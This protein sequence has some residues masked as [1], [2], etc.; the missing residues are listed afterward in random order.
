MSALGFRKH[1]PALD[2][3]RGLAILL[4]FFYHYAGGLTH[5][6]NSE[7]MRI[8]GAIFGFGWSGVDLFFVLS[9]FLITGILFDTQDDPHYFKN[10]YVRRSLRIFPV[11]YLFLLIYGLLAHYKFGVHLSL[12]HISFLFYVGYP[13]ALLWPSLA[14]ISP[15]VAIT[16][17]W[18]LAAEEQFYMVWPWL[19]WALKKPRTIIAACFAITVFS[20]SLRILF[21]FTGLHSAAWDY[22]FLPARMD[23]LAIGAIIAV[24]M[25]GRTREQ[26]QTAAWPTLAV[27]ALSMVFA[28]SVRRTVDHGDPLIST[29]GFTLDAIAFGALLVIVIRQGSWLGRVFSTPLLRLF[30][31][32]SYGLYLY[33]FPLSIFLSPMRPR[34]IMAVHSAG[35]GSILFILFSMIINLS[36]AALSFQ[37]FESP[38]LKLK[39]KFIYEKSGDAAPPS[40]RQVEANLSPEQ[41]AST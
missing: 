4:V 3:L 30:G 37:L 14:H 35:L 21:Y 31:K 36:L 8:L 7:M 26:L 29:L 34:F 24:V 6:A 23:A 15:V 32:Y 27:A 28:L 20:P 33:H 13:V 9:G 2:G 5:T 12:G 11:Y 17:L 22:A 40:P 16:H 19:I 25:R 10:F 41:Q 38:I 1:L 39:A 18:S